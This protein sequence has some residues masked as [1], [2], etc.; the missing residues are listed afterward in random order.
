[1]MLKMCFLGENRCRKK[2]S[3]ILSSVMLVFETAKACQQ[4][5]H[6]RTQFLHR[7]EG[8]FILYSNSNDDF[9]L[10]Y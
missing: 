2:I 10:S 7:K 9:N 1:M 8:I 5:S 3:F 4:I 6:T